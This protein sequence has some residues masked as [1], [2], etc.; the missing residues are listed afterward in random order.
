M[1]QIQ[2][3]PTCNIY[4]A[5]GGD[6]TRRDFAVTILSLVSVESVLPVSRTLTPDSASGALT[7]VS[8]VA[9][10]PFNRSINDPANALLSLVSCVQVVPLTRSVSESANGALTLVSVLQLAPVTRTLTTETPVV[11]GLSLLSCVV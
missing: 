7:L 5:S 11:A 9:A 6:D 10:G 8:C 3:I 1:W 4:E 2:S